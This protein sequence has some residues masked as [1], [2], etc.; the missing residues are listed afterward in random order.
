MKILVD[1]A[2][3]PAVLLIGQK[4][5]TFMKIGLK[6]TGLSRIQDTPRMVN[7]QSFACR[8]GIR[9]FPD[10]G[11]SLRERPR[12]GK[13][14]SDYEF[15]G[16]VNVPKAALLRNRRKPLAELRQIGE[17]LNVTVIAEA[18]RNNFMAGLVNKAKLSLS[19]HRK[20]LV[21]A[22]LRQNGR[23]HAQ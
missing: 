21:V 8:L 17:I 13:P 10:C 12:A 1:V 18:R 23:N 11:N 4:Q 5:K 3:F 15:A 7:P 6:V 14:G 2:W 19:Y 22:G 16:A 20:Q 9:P